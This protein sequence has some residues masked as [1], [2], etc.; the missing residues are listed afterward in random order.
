MALGLPSE[1]ATG[2]DANASVGE[3][4]VV[5]CAGEATGRDTIYTQLDRKAAPESFVTTALRLCGERPYCKFMGWTNPIMKPDSDAMND[6]QRAAMSFSF[7]LPSHLVSKINPARSRLRGGSR[8]VP[9]A[10]PLGLRAMVPPS[11]STV[12]AVIPAI[13]IALLFTQ[14]VW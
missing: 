1:L 12:A 2:V 9:R 4:R 7:E 11:G 13:S 10:E 6:V 5:F 8:S 3:A 14:I